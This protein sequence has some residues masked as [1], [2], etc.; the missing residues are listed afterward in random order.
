MLGIED[1]G[2]IL[3]HGG[4]R[5]DQKAFYLSELGSKIQF[6]VTCYLAIF[7]SMHASQSRS[8]HPRVENSGQYFPITMHYNMKS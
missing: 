5:R 7:R 4:M 1:C 8:D 3:R 6:A 2:F